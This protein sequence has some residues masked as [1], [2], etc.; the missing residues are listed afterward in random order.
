MQSPAIALSFL[1]LALPGSSG[2]Q[3]LDCPDVTTVLAADHAPASTFP[4]DRLETDIGTTALQGGDLSGIAADLRVELPEASD[5][6]IADVMAAAYCAFLASDAPPDH[7][8]EAA[9]EAFE[10]Q[11]DRTVFGSAPPPEPKLR[12]WLYG[13]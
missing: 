10:Q 11:I 8:T 1:L 12:G 7:R 2:A 5:A 13:N 3:P 6:E 4:F 9:V